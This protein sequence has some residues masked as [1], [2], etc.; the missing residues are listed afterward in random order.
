M[1][2]LLEMHKFD[3]IRKVSEHLTSI[4]EW[5][6]V[7][8]CGLIEILVFNDEDMISGISSRE[9]FYC[10][11]RKINKIKKEKLLWMIL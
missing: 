11:L 5:N 4:W 1:D 6:I 8:N 3:D 9:I 10:C 2:I 7:L